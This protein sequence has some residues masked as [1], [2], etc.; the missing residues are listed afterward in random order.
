MNDNMPEN[1]RILIILLTVLLM[2]SCGTARKAV[3]TPEETLPD[4]SGQ[5][6]QADSTERP[7]TFVPLH[8]PVVVP[9]TWRE[10]E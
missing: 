3:D 1:P 5:I 9:H 2:I 8:P 10:A 6:H 4:Q 7:D